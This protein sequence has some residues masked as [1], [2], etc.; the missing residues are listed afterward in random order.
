MKWFTDHHLTSQCDKIIPGVA[1]EDRLSDTCSGINQQG[2][3]LGQPQC[4]ALGPPFL[5]LSDYDTG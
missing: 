1:R 5:D 3:I 2:F 4:D